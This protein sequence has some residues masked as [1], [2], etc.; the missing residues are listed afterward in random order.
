M[1][2]R[3]IVFFLVLLAIACGVV[4]A[5]DSETSRP[6]RELV[7]RVVP[8]YPELARRLQIYGVVKLRATVAANGSVKLI[9]P[10][11][12]NPVLMKAAQEA[13]AGWKYAPAPTE[14]QELVELRFHTPH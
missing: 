14:T 3:L 9:E 13:V 5:Q 7:H 11:G 12:G 10:V 4:S 2:R 8:I 6:T 1:W